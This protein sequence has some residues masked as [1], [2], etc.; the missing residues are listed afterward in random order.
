MK[1]II[2]SL[3]AGLIV[4]AFGI[5]PASAHLVAMPGKGLGR[6]DLEAKF[7]GKIE[8][9]RQRAEEKFERTEKKFERKMDRKEN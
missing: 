2:T 8:L 5:I 9:K 1:R 7:K 6:P 3:T 4:L